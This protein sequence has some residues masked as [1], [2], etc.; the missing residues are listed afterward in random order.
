M[1]SSMMTGA[2]LL[3][4]GSALPDISISNEMLSKVVNTSDEWIS[5]RTGIKERRLISETMSIIDL[6]YSASNQALQKAKLHAQH[7]DLIIVATSSPNDLFGCA[8]QLQAKIGATNAAAFDITAACSGFIV[9]L[10][11]ASQ[12]IYTGS[13]KTILIV[14]ADILS[15]W[16]DWSDRNTCILFGD[17]AGAA[18]L[19]ANQ[20]N[21][22]LGFQLNTNGFESNQLCLSYTKTSS[23][24]YHNDLLG[25]KQGQFSHITMN[26]KEVYKFAV[27]KVPESITQC[28]NELNLSTDDISWLILHQANQRILNTVADKLNIPHYKLISNLQYYGNTSAASIPI[29]LDEACKKGQM[30]NGDIIVMSGFGA[31]LTWGTVI[32]QW[33]S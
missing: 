2:Y 22:I 24:S 3:S 1:K 31:G 23:Q 28:L 11:T 8:S 15:Q 13:Y 6:A 17:G 32:I 30:K 29:A 5:T 18:I 7:L 21:Y 20:K 26:G 27:S 12:F 16:V 14:G 25:I 19:Q 33:H 10:I 9:G 4:T